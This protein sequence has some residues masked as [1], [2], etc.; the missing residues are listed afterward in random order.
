MINR[1]SFRKT[2]DK[3]TWK[4]LAARGS[5]WIMNHASTSMPM[6]DRSRIV[7]RGESTL[8]EPYIR[9]PVLFIH[10]VGRG[11]NYERRM[12]AHFERTIDAGGGAERTTDVETGSDVSTDSCKSTAE[13]FIDGAVGLLKTSSAPTYPCFVVP[14]LIAFGSIKSINGARRP[15]WRDACGRDASIFNGRFFQWPLIITSYDLIYGR[16]DSGPISP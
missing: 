2:R 4:T 3:I 1:R 14:R 11:S 6:K 15:R 7:Q 9:R 8:E 12:E 13:L 5:R 10:R 16:I